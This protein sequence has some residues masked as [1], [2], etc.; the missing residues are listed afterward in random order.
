MNAVRIRNSGVTSV[1]DALRAANLGATNLLIGEFLVRA[2]D[3]G[4][5]LH[6]LGAL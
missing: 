5:L 3:P 2:E 4:A 1:D 6:E